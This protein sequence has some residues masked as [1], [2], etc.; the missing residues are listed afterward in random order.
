MFYKISNSLI[1]HLLNQ[2]NLVDVIKQKINLINKGNNYISLCPF[3]TEK[4]PSFTVSFE[5]Q[6]FYCF[7]CKISGNVIDFLVKFNNCSFKEAIN[8]LA[9]MNNISI[10]YNIVNKY[11]KY[12]IYLIILNKLKYLFKKNLI[13]YRKKILFI[14]SR[15][16][17]NKIINKFDIGLSCNIKINNLKE[18]ILLNTLGLINIKK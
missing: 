16:L 4:T 6:F 10:K 12:N 7:G 14:Q 13:K 3:H 1:K 5:K 11:Y 8:E 15:K 2:T 9:I 18:K 17:S